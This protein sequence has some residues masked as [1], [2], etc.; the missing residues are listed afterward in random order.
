MWI[1]CGQQGP[2]NAD[3]LS[4]EV[5]PV[6]KEC[7][8]DIFEVIVVVLE[9]K[10]SRLDLTLQLLQLSPNTID[11]CLI[12]RCPVIHQFPLLHLPLLPQPIEFF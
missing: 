10:F 9:V 3:I 4:A 2:I 12:P 11:S 7:R 1:D 6:V 8:S 5:S